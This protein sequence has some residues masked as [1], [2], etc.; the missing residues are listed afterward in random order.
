LVITRCSLGHR[1]SW[2]SSTGT[3]PGVGKDLL[4]RREVQDRI[5]DAPQLGRRSTQ[6]DTSWR[7]HT[8]GEEST[9]LDRLR[10]ENA[11]LRCANDILK[12]ATSF[13]RG[14]IRPPTDQK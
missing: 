1:V 14:G 4:D 7:A 13:L 11:E 6:I 5:R 12:A 8:T 3:A 2:S 9:E 10:Q